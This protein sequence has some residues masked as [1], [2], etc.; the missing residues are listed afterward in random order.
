[1]QLDSAN[2]EDEH[3]HYFKILKL[4]D[5]WGHKEWRGKGNSEDKYFWNSIPP[6]D[7]LQRLQKPS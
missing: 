5:P 7:E 4:R 2:L 1:M 3:H 6:S